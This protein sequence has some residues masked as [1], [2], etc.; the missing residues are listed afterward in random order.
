MCRVAMIPCLLMLAG[1]AQANEKVTFG[2][3]W[4][5]DKVNFGNTDRQIRP[6]E[7]HHGPEALTLPC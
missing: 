5:A 4:K 1:V 3:D 6:P 2:L 7:T